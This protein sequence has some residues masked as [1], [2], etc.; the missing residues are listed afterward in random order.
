MKRLRT[1]KEAEEQFPDII[2]FYYKDGARNLQKLSHKILQKLRFDVEYSDFYSLADEIFLDVLCRYDVHQNFNGFLYSCLRN[3]FK[4]EMS[5]RTQ[6]LKRKMDNEAI[7]LDS[8]LGE[9]SNYTIADIVKSSCDVEITVENIIVNDIMDST[10]EVTSMDILYSD[11][12]LQYVQKLSKMQRKILMYLVDGYT[13]HEIMKFLHITESV[14]MN[15]I[16]CIRAT[17]NVKVLY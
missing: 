12:I 8:S 7:S 2:N 6:T 3:K 4:S 1:L 14:Y 17:E 9:D 13:K 5:K 10:S 11:S 16:Q 15:N